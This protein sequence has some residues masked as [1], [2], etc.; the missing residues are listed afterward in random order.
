MILTNLL[1][2]CLLIVLSA[3]FVA[4]EF[5]IVRVRPTRIEQLIAEGNSHAIS[6]KQIIT[7]MDGFLSACQLGI[8]IT[9]LGLGWLGEPTVTKLFHPLLDKLPISDAFT[10][11]LS[12]LIAF[13]L[14]TYI[15]VVVG[16][17]FP[18]SIAIQQ[19]EKV[20]LLLSKPLLLFYK[21]MYPFIWILNNAARVVVRLYGI[22]QPT[23]ETAHSEEELQYV[24]AESYKSGEITTSEYRYVNNIFEFDNRL[25]NEI[26]VPRTQMITLCEDLPLKEII[27]I[28]T[29]ERFTRYPITKEDNKDTIIGFVHIKQLLTDC[30]KNICPEEKPL[31]KYAQPII[32]VMEFI[33]IQLLLMRM[34]KDHINIAILNDEFGGTAGLVTVEDILEEIVGEIRDELD[35]DEFPLIQKIHDNHYILDSKLHLTEVNNL[36]S[37]HLEHNNIH[38]IGG[39]LL[40]QNPDLKKGESIFYDNYEFILVKTNSRQVSQIEVKAVAPSF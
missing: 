37:M 16:E 32:H 20:A 35:E 5:A 28:I 9:S 17:L 31:K 39:W 15:N 8:T 19:T 1:I 38:T 30:I 36:L 12:F 24:L 27:K 23:I 34:Q 14:V 11:I 33:P 22:K 2:V 18:K 21:V 25:A 3:F 6:V 26:M 13:C 7:N 4:S 40:S 10:H 29:A